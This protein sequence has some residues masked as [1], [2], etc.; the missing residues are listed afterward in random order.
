MGHIWEKLINVFGNTQL[1]LQNKLGS[2]EKFSGLDKM[3]DDE[4]I[5]FV[6]SAMTSKE[7]Y[8]M[9]VGYKTY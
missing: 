2:I 5:A 8:T 4:K 3:K 1:L 6:L 9:V 7:I